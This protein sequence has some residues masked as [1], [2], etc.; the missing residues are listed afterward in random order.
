MASRRLKVFQA[1]VGFFESVVA[2]PS[3]KA[4]LEAWGVHQDLFHQGLAAETADPEARDAAL[5][6]PGVPML[7]AAGSKDRF[8]ERAAA[9]PAPPP[10]QAGRARRG[11]PARRPPP[12]RGEL[13][14]AERALEA[15]EKHHRQQAEALER[16]RDDLGRRARELQASSQ[17]E[18]RRLKKEVEKARRAFVRAGGKA[19]PK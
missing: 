9:P 15:A 7:R 2:A 11:A 8:A 3:R 14:E 5:S 1:H 6:R 10:R 19:E 13:D 4:A 16:E 17:V 12:D 18:Q